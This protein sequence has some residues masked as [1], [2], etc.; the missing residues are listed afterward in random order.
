MN[1]PLVVALTAAGLMLA[2]APAQAHA[3]LVNAD[4]ADH[5]VVAAPKRLTLHFS[6]KLEPKFSGFMLMKADGSAVAMTIAAPGPDR[7]VMEGAPAGTLAPGGYKVA[8]H[9]VAADGHKTQG[10]LDFTVR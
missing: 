6:E 2:G 1:T 3:R 5:A 8:W 9:A 7:T 10:L 4:P